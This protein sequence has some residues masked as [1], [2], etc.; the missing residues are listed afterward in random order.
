MHPFIRSYQPA[1]LSEILGQENA[2]KELKAIGKRPLLLYGPSGCGKTCSAHALANEKQWEIIEINASDA[3]SRDAIEARI[4]PALH[5]QSLFAKQKIVL[6]DEVDSLSGNKDRGGVSAIVQV[7][8]ESPFPIILT[9]NNPWDPKYGSLRSKCRLVEF[10]ELDHESILSILKKICEK[11][12]IRYDKS[13]LS[14]I[15]HRAGGD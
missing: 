9:A 3:R 10:G 7:M 13:S 12:G 5:Q 2:V 4:G 11:E 1:N 15:A 6:I 8:K 14:G